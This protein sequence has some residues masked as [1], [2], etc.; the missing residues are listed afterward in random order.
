M[1]QP[2]L[3]L[4][5]RPFPAYQLKALLLA[6]SLLALIGI[7]AWQSYGYL[8]YS[9]L[10]SQIQGEARNAE[11]ETVTLGRRLADKSSG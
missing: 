10:T 7:S 9:S 3:N 6:A 5:T 2:D 11:V 1:S 4:S 8:Q